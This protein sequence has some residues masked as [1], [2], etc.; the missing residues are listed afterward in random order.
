M[1]VA[2]EEVFGPVIFVLEW[3]DEDELLRMAN[4]VDY[5]LTASIYTDDLE[6][7]HRT[8]RELEAGYVWVNDTASHHMGAPFGGWKQSGVG[9]EEALDEVLAY[10]QKKNVNVSL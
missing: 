2:N 10:S 7:A 8:A 3:S 5:G 9:R 6:T 4:D 1:R